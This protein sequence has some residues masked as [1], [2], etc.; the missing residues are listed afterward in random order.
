MKLKKIALTLAAASAVL[1][2]GMFSVHAFARAAYAYEV[3]YYSDASLT[4]QVGTAYFNCTGRKVTGGQ[5]TQYSQVL[6]KTPCS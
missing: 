6:E 4:Q 2:A 5:V 1:A 3:G